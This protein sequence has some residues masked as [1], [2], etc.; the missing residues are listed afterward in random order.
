MIRHTLSFGV[1][2]LSK[3]FLHT[4][5]VD[6]L[7]EIDRRGEGRPVVA[8]D[9]ETIVRLRGEGKTLNA[10]AGDMNVSRETIRRRLKERAR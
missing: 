4:A 5:A 7:R 3:S 1:T 2:A 10:I 8:V 9:I 6:L